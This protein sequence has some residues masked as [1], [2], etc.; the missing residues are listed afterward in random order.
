MIIWVARN[1]D[2]P[3]LLYCVSLPITEIFFLTRMLPFYR[4]KT[5]RAYSLNIKT[6]FFKYNNVLNFLTISQY[7]AH[8]LSS[9]YNIIYISIKLLKVNMPMEMPTYNVYIYIYN[10]AMVF[11][12]IFSGITIVMI[13]NQ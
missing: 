6:N 4:Y 10:K 11:N 13:T 2:N 8:T 3:P 5:K 1:S 9:K 12:N 7:K